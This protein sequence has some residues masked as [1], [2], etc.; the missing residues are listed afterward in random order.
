MAF[1][2][3]N[4]CSSVTIKENST[5]ELRLSLRHTSVSYWTLVVS[6]RNGIIAGA[7]KVMILKCNELRVSGYWTRHISKIKSKA[8]RCI[9]AQC[10]HSSC[11]TAVRSWEELCF[12]A[13]WVDASRNSLHQFKWETTRHG[14]QPRGNEP[15]R[16]KNP[17]EVTDRKTCHGQSQPAITHSKHISKVQRGLEVFAILHNKQFKIFK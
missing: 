4:N 10:W 12:C 11:C 2:L 13:L 6:V 8:K 15:W 14:W 5:K 3:W 9:T 16:K 7:E 17:S 1:P